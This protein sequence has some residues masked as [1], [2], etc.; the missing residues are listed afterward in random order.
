M[1]QDKKAG[2][3]ADKH[4]KI[5]WALL[6]ALIAALTV[7]AV[8]R[9]WK[10][11]SLRAMAQ[12]LSGAKPGWMLLA[13][14][15]MLGFIYF[16]GCAVR[17]ACVALRYPT[18]RRRGFAYAAADIYFSA[19]TPSA[20]GGQPACV[21]MMRSFGVPGSVAAA[22]L[23]LTLTMY[24]LSILVVGLLVLI[25][26]P[27]LFLRFSPLA[28][29]LIAA[30]TVIQIGLLAVFLLLMCSEGLFKRLCLGLL[31]LLAKLRLL[32][33]PERKKE[34]L[35]QTMDEYHRRAALLT[36]HRPLLLRS[37]LYNLLQRL[38]AISV[39]MFV[40][41]ALGGE[42]RTA[43]WIFAVQSCVVLGSNCVPIPGAMGVADYLMLDGFGAFLSPD[44]VVILELVSRSLSFYSCVLLCGL[45]VLFVTLRK[46]KVDRNDRLL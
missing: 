21:L 10:G 45:V 19:I 29:V 18:T 23:M 30:G 36:G 33:D 11:F 6:S 5:S 2:K 34:R 13:V 15:A 35:A 25:L 44:R 17:S 24:A 3:A 38:S 22:V 27:S 39:S 1:E 43:P 32:R 40:F 41:L 26:A 31:D 37:F 16:E 28:R 20:S 9:Q 8:S 12:A 42:A 14:A 4:K 46:R 7:W